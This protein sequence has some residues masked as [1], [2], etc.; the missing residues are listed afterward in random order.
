M[1]LTKRKE[2]T[3]GQ[4]CELC[5]TTK[6]CSTGS[7]GLYFCQHSRGDV[8]AFVEIGPCRRNTHFH[9]Y[10]KVGDPLLY[11]NQGAAERSTPPQGR[12]EERLENQ[13][14][15]ALVEKAKTF[16]AQ[17]S[18][19]SRDELAERLG[20]PESCFSALPLLGAYPRERNGACWIFPEVN[21]QGV[22]IGLTRRWRNGQKASM[23][24]SKRGICM[25]KGWHD[26]DGPIFMPEGASDTLTLVAL[27]LNALGRPSDSAG[28]KH[29]VDALDSLDKTRSLVVLGEND[30]KADGS[31]PGR[32]NARVTARALQELL[33]RKVFWTLPPNGA[34]DV[35]E[36]ATKLV[37][38]DQCLEDWHAMG[39]VFLGAVK[40]IPAYE[41]AEVATAGLVTTRMDS[42]EP[43]VIRWLIPHYFPSG[44]LTLFGADSTMGKSMVVMH[45]AAQLS[46]GKPCFGLDYPDHAPVES[47]IA[48]LEDGRGKSIRPRLDALGADL[49]KI[50]LLDGM[51]DSKGR[52]MPWGLGNLERLQAHLEA[53]PGIRYV[54]LDPVDSYLFGT[55]VD[56]FR[57]ASLR[58]KIVDPLNKL[59]KEKD[60]VIKMVLHLNKGESKKAVNR[61]ANSIAYYT[62][63]RVGYMAFFEPGSTERRV[64]CCQKL[65]N[66]KIPMSI[67]YKIGLVSPHRQEQV[68]GKLRT[69]FTSDDKEAYRK[70]LAIA[71][72]IGFTE[73]TGDDCCSF[74]QMQ[75]QENQFDKDKGASWLRSFL[76]GGPKP[77]QECL[78]EGNKH[79]EANHDVRW[80]R[81][82]VLGPKLAGQS[83]RDGKYSRWVWCLPSQTPDM[84]LPPSEE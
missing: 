50:H 3:K 57:A 16:V 2:V 27:G 77:A 70:Q 46:R 26:G 40:W 5:G 83:L 59:A 12:K 78:T 54:V 9:M 62:G 36:W 35:R 4:P 75:E 10:R 56:D 32:D 14:N 17:F 84:T 80:W 34:K 22:L 82:K 47:L 6:G 23:L 8:S 69:T 19:A 71:E 28:T 73:L 31:W 61:L 48:N 60:I 41:D 11:K 37:G 43:E 58:E 67:L 33:K 7:D 13:G 51:K 1:Q 15:D 20:L 45:I 21:G 25:P 64:F 66:G 29:L 79:L 18:Q 65:Q 52:T 76:A 74:E 72:W 63:S 81:D 30:A 53:N 24:G 39:E 42:V 55:G 68:V 38:H 44:E 49:T